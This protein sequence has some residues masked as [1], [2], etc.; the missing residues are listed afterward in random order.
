MKLIPIVAAAG[1]ILS[2]CN[3]AR[4]DT[5]WW[6]FKVIDM[7]SGT[8]K[9][10]DYTPPMKASKPWKICVLFPH[11]KDTFWVAVDYGIAQEAERL[12][13]VDDAL[14]GGRLRKSRDA[15]VAVR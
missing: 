9:T 1:L 3:G 5:P 15:A 2:A 12:G 6:P 4:A 8:P 14:S 7:S 11:M 13:V 10:V